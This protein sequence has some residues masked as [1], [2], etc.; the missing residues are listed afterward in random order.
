MIPGADTQPFPGLRTGAIGGDQQRGVQHITTGEGNL[1]ATFKA[2]NARQRIRCPHA[3]AGIVEQGTQQH[4]TQPA[5]FHHR[6]Q[7]MDAFFLR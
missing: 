6:T 4:K 5:V 1:I 7:L 2:A 3:D